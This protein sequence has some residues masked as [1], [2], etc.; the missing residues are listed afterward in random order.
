MT[1]KYLLTQ[2]QYNALAQTGP[3]AAKILQAISPIAPMTLRSDREP[4]TPENIRN[5]IYP[6]D[7]NRLLYYDFQEKSLNTDNVDGYKIQPLLDGDKNDSILPMKRYLQR[8]VC[9]EA[10]RGYSLA[11][12]AVEFRNLHDGPYRPGD[13]WSPRPRLIWH[14]ANGYVATPDDGL[15]FVDDD[16]ISSTMRRVNP[17]WDSEITKA[18]VQY[19]ARLYWQYKLNT[20]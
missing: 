5:A 19:C 12:V 1:K 7:M 11:A 2:A 4:L 8:H 17:E 3:A 14:D 10:Y 13:L 6:R 18:L 16:L 9:K 15:P 20:R